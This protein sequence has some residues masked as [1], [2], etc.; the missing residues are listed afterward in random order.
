M[1][2]FHTSN[3]S[4]DTPDTK[5]PVYW[6]VIIFIVAVLVLWGKHAQWALWYL[7]NYQEYSVSDWLI[8]YEGGF[9]RRGLLGQLLWEAYQMFPFDVRKFVLSLPFA[10]SPLLLALLLRIFYKEKWSPVVL[11]SYCCFGATFLSSSIRRDYLMLIMVYAIFLMASRWNSSCRK[12]YFYGTFLL[13]TIAI[14][15]YEPI[16]FIIIPVFFF[17]TKERL[18]VW[19]LIPVILVIFLSKGSAETAQAIW[20]SWESLFKNYPF[21]S[22]ANDSMG[23]GV[24]ALGWE[25]VPTALFH[26]DMAYAGLEPSIMS[27]PLI[28]YM[29]A[30][31]YYLITH[32][33]VAVLPFWKIRN[34]SARVLSNV[35][36]FHTIAMLPM[37]T[38]LS[39]DWGRNITFICVSTFFTI[40]F[41][42]D[43]ADRFPQIDRLTHRLLTK[44]DCCRIFNS[45]YLYT[46]IAFTIPVPISE[47][48]RLEDSILG[49]F[50]LLLYS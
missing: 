41:F 36:I 38:F 1:T 26:L 34:F 46:F 25:I 20:Q 47:A 31:V 12:V 8:N 22:D 44:M 39:C 7:G 24:Q 11:L 4:V 35:L 6:P 2:A 29:L 33:N 15:C 49:T 32:L 45:P 5:T 37:L 40:H 18:L 43:I 13:S 14:L 27:I 50:I 16:V 10:F 48:P 17:A 21:P 42:P 9:V 23:L 19:L 28:L 3:V 30:G